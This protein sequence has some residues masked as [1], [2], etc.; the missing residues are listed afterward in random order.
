M[1]WIARRILIVCAPSAVD[2]GAD[3]DLGSPIAGPIQQQAPIWTLCR[4]LIC[5]K[6][7]FANEYGCPTMALAV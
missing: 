4:Q 7:E 3:F 2:D 1:T 5:F 6:G